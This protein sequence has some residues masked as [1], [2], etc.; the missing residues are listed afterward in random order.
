MDLEH[1]EQVALI[2][3]AGRGIGAAIARKLSDLGAAVLLAAR[4]GSEIE[5]VASEIRDA[6]GD[7]TTC[8]ADVSDDSSV[9]NLFDEVRKSHGSLDILINNAGIGVF[10]PLEDFKT[11]DFDRVLDVNL[12]GC[13]LCCREAL[14]L[15]LPRDKGTIVN[16]ASV[17]GFKGYPLQ[18][19]YTASKHGVMG[20]T[21]SLIA[22]T[23]DSGIRVSAVLPGGVDTE[24][25]RAARPDLA[26]AD[27]MHPDDIADAVAYLLSLSDR[28][29]VD[30]IYI[31]RRSS[32]S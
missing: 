4:T 16:I 13:F 21:R 18:G 6:G 1:R 7:A 32:A 12:R 28:A 14:R 17:V 23:Q 2:T 11:E 31:R 20:L 29:A 10:G 22:E 26:P 5:A 25:V 27:L 30:E 19:A 8:V 3:G 24:M 15:M 9:K